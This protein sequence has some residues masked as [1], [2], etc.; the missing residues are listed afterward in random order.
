MSGRAARRKGMNFEREVVALLQAHG[1]A[2]E[3]VPL[4]GAVKGGKFEGDIDCP[5][6]GVDQKLECKRWKGGFKTINALLQRENTYGLVVRDDHCEALI[7][8]RLT[9]FAKLAVTPHE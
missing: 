3:K 8:L 6:R 4:S 2:A 9:D 7:V 1:I 5:V